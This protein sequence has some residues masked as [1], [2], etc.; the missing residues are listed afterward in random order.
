MTAEGGGGA[1][2]EF[3]GASGEGANDGQEVGGGRDGE[4]GGVKGSEIDKWRSSEHTGV[5]KD[6]NL[7]DRYLR[8]MG[9]ILG[10]ALVRL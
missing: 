3:E 9:R 2:A 10:L 4:E 6:K 1:V 8:F 7:K 5:V